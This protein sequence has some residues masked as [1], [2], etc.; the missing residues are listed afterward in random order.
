MSSWPVLIF[1]STGSRTALPSSRNPFRSSRRTQ[2]RCPRSHL[3]PSEPVIKQA[4]GNGCT[5]SASRPGSCR[6]VGRHWKR[7]L[8]ISLANHRIKA[9]AY[10]RALSCRP[11][12]DVGIRPFAARRTGSPSFKQTNSYSRTLLSMSRHFRDAAARRI[13]FAPNK[14]PLIRSPF[15]HL[16][17]A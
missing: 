2:R 6:R 3:L 16:L 4:R 11:A 7:R 10:Q 14:F 5:M 12:V 15:L 9:A 13:L 17:E 1:I 8:E